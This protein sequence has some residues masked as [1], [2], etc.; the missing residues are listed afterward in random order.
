[1]KIRLLCYSL[2][3]FLI[4]KG[5]MAQNNPQSIKEKSSEDKSYVLMDVSYINDA[6]F[7]GRRDSIAAPYLYPYIGYYDKSG[8]FADSS[9]S[10]LTGSE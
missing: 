2:I 7:M 6:V 10:Y 1:M 3:A 5:L 8:L 4:S 9:V